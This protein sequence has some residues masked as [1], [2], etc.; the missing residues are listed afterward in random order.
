MP[1][2]ALVA[3]AGHYN[4]EIDVDALSRL[5]VARRA[6]R[7][8]VEEFELADGRRIHLLAG[9]RLVNLAAGEGH[10]A[11]IMDMSFANQALSVE[12]LVARPG[13]LDPTV[14]PVPRDIDRHVAALKLKSLGVRIDTL[15]AEQKRY[16]ASWS[17]GT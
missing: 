17:E 12:F 7:D 13:R 16:L 10:P 11:A 15:S 6:V 1:D 2:N 14:L 8:L 4:V 5:A 9:G 3:N